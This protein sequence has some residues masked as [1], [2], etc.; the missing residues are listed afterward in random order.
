MLSRKDYIEFANILGRVKDKARR[1]KCSHGCEYPNTV[2]IFDITGELVDYFKVDN[3]NFDAE[4][5]HKAIDKE[6]KK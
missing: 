2:A 1:D 5:F 4:K 6:V 3:P